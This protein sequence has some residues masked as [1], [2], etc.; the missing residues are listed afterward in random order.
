MTRVFRIRGKRYR[1]NYHRAAA[2]AAKAVLALA[3]GAFYAYAF[4]MALGVRF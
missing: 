1:W 2:N 4:I 3:T